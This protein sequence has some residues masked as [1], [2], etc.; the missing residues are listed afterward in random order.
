MNELANKER[1]LTANEIEAGLITAI[2]WLCECII[3]N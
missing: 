1:D 3:N 2:D